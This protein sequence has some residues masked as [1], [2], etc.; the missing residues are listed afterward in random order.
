MI[1]LSR[2]CSHFNT[3]LL[4]KI[5]N[6]FLKPYI[7]N[8]FL[9]YNTYRINNF[10]KNSVNHGFDNRIKY[11]TVKSVYKELEDDYYLKNSEEDGIYYLGVTKNKFKDFKEI[12]Y[13]SVTDEET[14]KRGDYLFS[15][16]DSKTLFDFYSPIDCKVESVNPKFL[17][18]LTDEI[19]SDF[20]KY[21]ESPN[22][23]L[24]KV[25]LTSE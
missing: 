14:L 7:S 18:A 3:N 12:V 15:V 23:Y 17:G 16:E 10:I 6:I 19:L 1:L 25:K 21:P 9:T 8:T 20:F 2:C 24:A 5:P 11:G 4:K 13:I 22:N